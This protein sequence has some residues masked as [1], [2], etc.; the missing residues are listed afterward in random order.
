MKNLTASNNNNFILYLCGGICG[1]IGTLSY[2]ITITVPMHPTITYL[3]AMSWP[4]LSIIFAYSLYHYVATYSQS[5]FNQLSFIM[6]CIGFGMLAMMM[7]IQ[8]AVGIGME[9]YIS[10][11]SIS[12][13][14]LL[15]LMKKISQI[16]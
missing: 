1:L 8:L 7:S 9:D 16:D 6:A 13:P 4:L 10:T 3:M 11:S 5:A 2:I 14:D 15:H 12:N